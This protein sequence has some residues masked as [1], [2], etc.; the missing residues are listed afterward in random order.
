[1][2]LI[3]PAST[4]SYLHLCNGLLVVLCLQLTVKQ[5]QQQLHQLHM[6]LSTTELCNVQ[7]HKK[8]SASDPASVHQPIHAVTM[9]S[10]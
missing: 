10:A 3:N 4:L 8:T 6:H 9:N 5:P 2:V 7:N 1:M